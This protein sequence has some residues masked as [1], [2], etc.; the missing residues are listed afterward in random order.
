MV[1]CVGG[2]LRVRCSPILA[3][4]RALGAIFLACSCPLFVKCPCGV[5]LTWLT[6]D[7]LYKFEPQCTT[8]CIIL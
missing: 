7:A 8:Y 4:V 5:I 6:F 2:A 3:E 1:G